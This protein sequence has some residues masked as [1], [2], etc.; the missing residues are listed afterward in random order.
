[1]HVGKALRKLRNRRQLSVRELAKRADVNYT[2]VSKWERTAYPVGDKEKIEAVA[3]V[4]GFSAEEVLLHGIIAPNDTD[5]ERSRFAIIRMIMEMDQVCLNQ[6]FNLCQALA[7]PPS[8][9]PA[10]K[11]G[12]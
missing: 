1:M 3:G 12:A 11:K 4:L 6:V 2:T 7:A 9:A 10:G 5:Q 8:P